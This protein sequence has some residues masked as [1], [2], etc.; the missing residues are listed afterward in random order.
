[1]IGGYFGIPLGN[2][3]YV[4]L[5]GF[6]LNKVELKLNLDQFRPNL[7]NLSLNRA[8]MELQFK[9]WTTS[10]SILPGKYLEK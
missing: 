9:F 1:M 10:G 2:N 6:S 8:E 7:F 3:F 4:N 5:T